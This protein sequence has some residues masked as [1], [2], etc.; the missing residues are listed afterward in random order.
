M[1]ARKPTRCNYCDKSPVAFIEYTG[2]SMYHKPGRSGY[3]QLW[4]AACA[5]HEGCPNWTSWLNKTDA[6]PIVTRAA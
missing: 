3:I 1:K 2:Y 4:V 5:D 6:N